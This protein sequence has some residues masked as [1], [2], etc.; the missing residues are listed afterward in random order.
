[1]GLGW[2]LASRTWKRVLCI[3]GPMVTGPS[4]GDPRDVD[5]QMVVSVG[6]YMFQSSPSSSNS[7]ASFLGRASPPQNIL[8]PGDPVQPIS[9]SKRHV[10]G[11]ACITVALD[12][13]KS[14]INKL[15]SCAVS[16]LAR[17]TRA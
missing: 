6:P 11:V 8:S 10:A 12:S 2:S 4:A 14:L 7:F 1:M 3:G 17:T 9:R 15:G 5:D 16:R 13:F